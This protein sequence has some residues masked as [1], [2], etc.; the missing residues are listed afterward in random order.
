MVLE[1]LLSEKFQIRGVRNLVY[2]PSGELTTYVKQYL[3]DRDADGGYSPKTLSMYADS[4]GQFICFVHDN[5]L[6]SN[7]A[8]INKKYIVLFLK[9]LRDRKRPDGRPITPETVNCYYRSLHTFFNWLVESEGAIPPEKNPFIG[10]KPPKLPKKLVRAWK[11]ETTANVMRLAAADNSFTGQR[12]Y[13]MLLMMY[14]S[15]VR[16]CELVNMSVGAID[17][18]NG[19]IRVRG[20][21]NKERIVKMGENTQRALF[22]YLLR[23]QDQ[24]DAVWVSDEGV[25]LSQYGIQ[26][27]VRRLTA[28]A[29]TPPDMKR[30]THMF[31]HSGATDYLRNNGKLKCLQELMGHVHIETTEKYLDAL[32]SE[33]M[34]QD[35]KQASPVDNLFKS[36]LQVP[37]RPKK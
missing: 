22:Q 29:Q 37:K 18:N 5:K 33:A 36:G 11:P 4:I 12:N 17:A 6:P 35:H 14:D 15:L 26:M 21:G 9:S 3:L 7:L 28:R 34:I 16:R 32:G 8:D 13:A 19:T 2:L 27:A 23:R 30:G 24:C 10:L 25:P 1:H 31:R 20:K